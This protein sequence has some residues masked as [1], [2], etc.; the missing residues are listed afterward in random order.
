MDLTQLL[1]LTTAPLLEVLGGGGLF[2]QIIPLLTKEMN[3]F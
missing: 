3:P 1:M 2:S